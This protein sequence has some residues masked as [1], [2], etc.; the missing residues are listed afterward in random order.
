M[1]QLRTVLAV[2]DNTG[3]KLVQV[4]TVLGASRRRYARLGDV[5][6]VSVKAALPRGTVHKGDVVRAVVVRVRKAQRRVDGSLIRFGEN[7]AVLLQKGTK[8][9]LGTR[10]FGPTAREVRQAGFQKVTSLAAEVW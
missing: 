3:A 8:D 5:V 7:A 9:P 10:V 4:I 2:A 1:V 6:V